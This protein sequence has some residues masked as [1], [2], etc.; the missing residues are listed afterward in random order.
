MSPRR[1]SM[2]SLSI[3]ITMPGGSPRASA[4][5]TTPVWR[6]HCEGVQNVHPLDDSREYDVIIYVTDTPAKP[7]CLSR[8]PAAVPGWPFIGV[9]VCVNAWIGDSWWRGRGLRTLT[10]RRTLCGSSE[11]VLRRAGKDILICHN[12]STK[13]RL[14][15]AYCYL[16]NHWNYILDCTFKCWYVCLYVRAC[17]RACVRV[18]VRACVCIQRFILYN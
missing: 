1:A 9:Q 15:N 12:I 18:C 4:S 11:S 14:Q 6:I 5:W 2:S 3:A 10:W 13:Q 17:V 16:I 7:M 8:V